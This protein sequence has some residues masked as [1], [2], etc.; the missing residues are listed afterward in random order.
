MRRNE[1]VA[2]LK[3]SRREYIKLLFVL[4]AQDVCFKGR[5]QKSEKTPYFSTAL[6]YLFRDNLVKRM[7]IMKQN[8]NNSL[9]TVTFC[10]ICHDFVIYLKKLL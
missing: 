7:L 2:I 3:Q 9:F 1:F 5:Q 10:E 6:L 8:V 4:T